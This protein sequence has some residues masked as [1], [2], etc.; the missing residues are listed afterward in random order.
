VNGVQLLLIVGVGIAVPAL[1]R[2]R[3]V[4]PERGNQELQAIALF[5]TLGTLLI[6]GTTVK[7]VARALKFDL[8]AD[9]AE[10]AEMRERGQ[11]IIAEAAGG[12]GDEAFVGAARDRMSLDRFGLHPTRPVGHAG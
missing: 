5:V 11:K 9:R 12:D 8:A 1:A 7:A 3:G 4:E 2:R 10:D 6:Q